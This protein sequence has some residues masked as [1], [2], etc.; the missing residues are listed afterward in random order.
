HLQKTVKIQIKN[1][2]KHTETYTFSHVPADGLNWYADGKGYPSSVPVIEQD[3]ATVKFSQNKVKIPAGKSAKITLSF[4]EPK[5]GKAAQFPIYSGFVVA[6]PEKGNVPVHVPYTGLKGDVSKVPIMDTS[7][8][9]PGMAQLTNDGKLSDIPEDRTFNLAVSLPVIQT[10]IGSH[11]P[12][13]TI[14]VFDNKKAFKGF[15]SSDNL[16]NAIGWSGRQKNIDDDGHLVY[17]NWVWS[18]KVI[19][20]ANS[21]APV[22]LPSGTY[23]LVIASQKKLTAGSYPKDYEVFNLGNI[24]F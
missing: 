13:F 12:D 21:T 23:N 8:G 22:T 17:S 7:L 1:T 24:K 15:L 18:G 9:F 14:R 4:S 6:T 10:R 2:G 19:P 3:Y 5:N 11:T 16:G 20:A